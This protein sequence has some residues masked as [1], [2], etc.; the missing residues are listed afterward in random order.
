MDEQCRSKFVK[1][2]MKNEMD[3]V[4]KLIAVAAPKSLF[5][6]RYGEQRDIEALKENKVWIGRAI[7]LDDSEDARFRVKN[8]YAIC[9]C[10]DM[11]AVQNEKFKNHKYKR[12]VLSIADTSKKDSFVCSFSE[13]KKNEYMWENY[14]NGYN[15]FCIEYDFWELKNVNN[16]LLAPV[17]YSLKRE[18]D[19]RECDSKQW[20]VFMQL[21]TKY[22]VG[23]NGEHWSEQ[24]EW[25][26]ACYE[27]NLGVLDNEKGKLISV[28][29]PKKI[30]F[31]KNMS[32]ENKIQILSWIKEKRYNIAIQQM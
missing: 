18:L 15:G 5:K 24:L 3:T 26:Y 30:I 22:P 6:Y 29:L 20:M 4:N 9:Q 7:Y 2:L 10:I 25:R 16:L 13:T 32:E 31:G 12:D 19:I 17:S 23:S 21:Y 14:A 28:P 8:T 1:A 11:L 27:K